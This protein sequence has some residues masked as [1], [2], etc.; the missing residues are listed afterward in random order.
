MGKSGSVSIDIKKMQDLLENLKQTAHIEVGV[1]AGKSARPDGG[2]TNATLASIHEYG[3]PVHNL[4]PRSM[5]RTPIHDHAKE[6]MAPFKGKVDA[7]LKKGTLLQMYKTI[8]VAAEKIVDQA[9]D[10]GGFGRWPSLTYKTLL[11]KSARVGRSLKTR[12]G[13]LAQIYAGLVGEG[14]LIRTAQLRR[15]FSSRVRMSF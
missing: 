11:A 10:T 9:F 8:G 2:L 4:P 5:L 13:K 7:L 6:I 15:S 14:I 1:F 3:S 12:K